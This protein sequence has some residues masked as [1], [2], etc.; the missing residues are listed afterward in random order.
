MESLSNTYVLDRQMIWYV[1]PK[2]AGEAPTNAP[3]MSIVPTGLRI[4]PRC[5]VNLSH[6]EVAQL[7]ERAGVFAPCLD[8]VVVGDEPTRERAP[9]SVAP[10]QSSGIRLYSFPR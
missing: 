5:T 1:S 9:I 7:Y 4:L 2:L 10:N 8:D 3:D 6:D